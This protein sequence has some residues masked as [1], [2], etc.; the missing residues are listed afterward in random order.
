MMMDVG[1]FRGAKNDPQPLYLAKQKITGKAQHFT[2]TVAQEPTFAG[3]DPCNKLIDR[4]PDDN[5]IAVS[6]Q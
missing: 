6:K 3:I 1:V 2:L 4:K 5:L